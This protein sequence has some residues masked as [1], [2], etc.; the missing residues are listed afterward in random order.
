MSDLVAP[1][2]RERPTPGDAPFLQGT[3]LEWDAVAGTNLVR[4]RGAEHENLQS[5]IGSETALVRPNDSVLV[6]KVNNTFAVLGRIELPGTAQ[7]ALAVAFAATITLSPP[8]VSTTFERRNGPEV[9][10]YIGSS[11]RAIVTLSAEI[12]ISNNVERMS[13]QVLGANNQV[14]VPAEVYRGLAISSAASEFQASR[15]LILT[16]DEGL[17]EGLLRFQTMHQTGNHAANVPL[18]GEVQITVQPF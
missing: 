14:V 18:V 1:S 3:V 8:T 11:R 7:R 4:V 2:S 15:I 9:S 5:L 10:V 13:V 12:V 17:T 6:I 16:E